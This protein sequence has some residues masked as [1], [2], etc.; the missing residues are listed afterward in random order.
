MQSINNKEQTFRIV[1]KYG[2]VVEFGAT[3]DV[4]VDD[5]EIEAEFRVIHAIASYNRSGVER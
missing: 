4:G 3:D 5:V 2:G 1:E